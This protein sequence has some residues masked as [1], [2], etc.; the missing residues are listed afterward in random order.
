M[1]TIDVVRQL[2]LQDSYVTYREIETTLGI[3]GTSLHS[4][5]H[6]HLTVEKNLFGLDPIQFVNRLKKGSCLL[7]YDIVTGD[8]SWIYAYESE[9]KHQSTVWVFQDEP[10][11]TKDARA[12]STSKQMIARF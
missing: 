12:R 5:L 7:V 3:S 6:E 1:E 10:N 8:E 11:P 4:I 2:I 9:S